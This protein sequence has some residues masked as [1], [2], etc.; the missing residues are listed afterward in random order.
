MIKA[1]S[2][3]RVYTGYLLENKKAKKLA[4][5]NIDKTGNKHESV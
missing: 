4:L 5:L 2:V 3:A 1:E